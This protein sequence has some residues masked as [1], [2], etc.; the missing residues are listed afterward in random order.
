VSGA[1]TTTLAVANAQTAQSGYEYRAVFTNAAGSA[2]SAVAKLTVN[3]PTAPVVSAITPTSGGSGT[4]VTITGSNFSGT[5]TVTFGA[6][7]LATSM[8]LISSTKITATAPGGVTVGSVVDVQVK[9]TVATSAPTSAD[10]F[11]YTH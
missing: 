11:T 10:Q 2:T 4:S 3:P 1:T 8:V 9:T 5:P 6:G 7:R